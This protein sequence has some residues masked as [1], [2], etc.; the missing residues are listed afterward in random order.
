MRFVKGKMSVLATEEHELGFNNLPGHL[1]G[2]RILQVS[3]VHMTGWSRRRER[4]VAERIASTP[5]DLVLLTGDFVNHGRHWHRL[6]DWLA[7]TLPDVPRFAVPGNWD[8][9]T[10][11]T[12]ASMGKAMARARVELL[13]NESRWVR[14]GEGGLRLVG[15]DD[16]RY[17][18][19]DLARAF[20]DV[21][22]DEFVVVACH[23]PDLLLH[24]EREWFQF[25]VCGHTHGGQIRIPGYGAVYTSTKLGR[26]FDNGLFPVDSDRYV[27]ISR[28]IGTGHIP[29]RICCPP[30]LALFRLRR[31][32]NHLSKP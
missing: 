9:K 25:L 22:P 32:L 17:G 29:V 21:H 10:D 2:L 13:V 16:V 26:R 14:H 11:D 24:V 28:G 20:A 27:Y 12:L 30:E 4:A 3:D 6:G 5:A 19:L 8:Y 23:S 18:G 7:E 1:D 31:I 15:V